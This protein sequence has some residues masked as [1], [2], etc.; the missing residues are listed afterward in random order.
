MHDI[1]EK[2]KTVMMEEFLEPD[3]MTVV[4]ETTKLSEIPNWDS[5]AA[6]NLQILINETFH[7]E[8][9]LDLLQDEAAFSDL[10]GFICEPATIA[11]AM[12][13]LNSRS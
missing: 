11:A 10:I 12:R 2:L 5:M 3:D 1:W 7:V 4:T 6:V 9:P 13:K 8:L